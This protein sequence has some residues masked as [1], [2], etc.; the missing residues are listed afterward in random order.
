MPANPAT[1]YRQ[2]RTDL[3]HR[4]IGGTTVLHRSTWEQPLALSHALNLVWT[5]LE[6]G[7]SA[8]EIVSDIIDVFDYDPN[9]V[10]RDV[11]LA[12]QQL[13][14]LDLVEPLAP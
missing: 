9:T 14:E 4:T 5:C 1:R 7:G 6:T 13:T 8:D 2:V 12:L 3:H 11:G 10:S